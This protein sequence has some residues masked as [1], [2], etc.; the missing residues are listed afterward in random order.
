[1]ADSRDVSTSRH[2]VSALHAHLVLVTKYRHEVLTDRHG[3]PPEGEQCAP[4]SKPNWSSSRENNHVHL[5]VNFPPKMALSS[6]PR[7]AG[8]PS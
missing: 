1:M 3:H 8:F 4:T 5:L 6:Y 7:P 2:R